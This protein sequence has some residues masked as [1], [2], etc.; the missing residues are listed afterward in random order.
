MSSVCQNT[1]TIKPRGGP[2]S[3][4]TPALIQQARVAEALITS[5]HMCARLHRA[6]DVRHRALQPQSPVVTGGTKASRGA[7]VGRRSATFAKH[8]HE[9]RADLGD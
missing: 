4:P 5:A 6:N 8:M 3:A 2:D 7:A 1:G 9:H